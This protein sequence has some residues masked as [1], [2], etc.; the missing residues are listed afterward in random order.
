MKKRELNNVLT[1]EEIVDTMVPP[2]NL[3]PEQQANSD[4][5][6]AIARR[7]RR[8]SLGKDANQR[9]QLR[10]LRFQLE[11][12]IQQDQFQPDKN[13]G[14]FLYEYLRITKR[15]QKEFANDIHIHHTTVTN[16]L[17]NRKKPNDSLIIRLELHSCNMI[18][19]IDWFKLHEM[20]KG[21]E[22]KTSTKLRDQEKAHIRH[23]LELAD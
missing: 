12:Y 3:S 18:P 10:K 20:E 1:A 17:K 22:I 7:N 19:A 21:Y 4:Q 15:K 23:Y 13:F 14:Y 16:L 8:E 9:F 6:L 11:E 5:M 2:V